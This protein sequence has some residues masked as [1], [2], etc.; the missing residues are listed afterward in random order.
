MAGAFKKR[1][2]RPQ[3]PPTLHD[4][5]EKGDDYADRTEAS[6]L[7]ELPAHDAKCQAE[8]TWPKK[9]RNQDQVKWWNIYHARRALIVRS[10]RSIEN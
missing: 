7:D 10:A 4:E 3:K 1:Q 5:Q 6:V 2:H 9:H 8:G